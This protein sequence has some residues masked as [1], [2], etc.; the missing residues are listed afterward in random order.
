MTS[1][2]VERP[3]LVAIPPQ[4]L[5]DV[6]RLPEVSGYLRDIELRHQGELSVAAIAREVLEQ[7]W[8]FWLVWDGT[9]AAV[10]A[11]E[12]YRDKGGD[13]RC[14]IPFCSGRDMDTWVGLIS[15]IE[16]YARENGCRRLDMIARKGW[17]KR[18]PAYKMTHVVLERML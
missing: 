14:R 15:V 1:A 7:R 18:L 9:A 8:H 10:L 4:H 2:A 3:Q 13:K 16:Q 11:T 17:A 12:I 6:L 5:A